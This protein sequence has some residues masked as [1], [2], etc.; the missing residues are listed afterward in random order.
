[1]EIQ[2]PEEIQVPG[3]ILDLLA[4]LA[5]KDLLVIRVSKEL[6]VPQDQLDHLDHW[7]PTAN[8]ALLDSPVV[9]DNQE[10]LEALDHPVLKD[11]KEILVHLDLLVRQDHRAIK[12]RLVILDHLDRQG[13]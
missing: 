9:L 6:R 12:D 5:Q 4:I 3:E 13:M 8:Q 1:V 11:F 10:L 2:V 7:E